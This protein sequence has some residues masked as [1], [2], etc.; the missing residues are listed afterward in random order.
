MISVYDED[1][2][3][4]SWEVLGSFEGERVGE[5]FVVE[6]VFLIEGVFFCDLSLVLNKNDV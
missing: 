2:I 4:I 5:E 3:M 1:E 6:L